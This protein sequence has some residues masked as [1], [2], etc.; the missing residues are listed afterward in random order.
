MKFRSVITCKLLGYYFFTI[1][2]PQNTSDI[3]ISISALSIS[4]ISCVVSTT[5]AAPRFSVRRPSFLVP[6]IG[7]IYGFLQISHARDICA[8]VAFLSSA[9]RCISENKAL[10][11]SYQNPSCSS[12]SVTSFSAPATS[13]AGT[14]KPSL[15]TVALGSSSS[16][17]EGAPAR[18]LPA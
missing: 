6:S 11:F 5:S 4:A 10:F 2:A 13:L 7:T 15:I 18:R 8:G 3:S 17:V 9:Y 16:M 14:E 12:H 1:F